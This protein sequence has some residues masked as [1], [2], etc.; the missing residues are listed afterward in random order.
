MLQAA[1]MPPLH[2]VRASTRP[3]GAGGGCATA[4]RRCCHAYARDAIPCDVV[5][6]VVGVGAVLVHGHPGQPEAQWA[7]A[8]QGVSLRRDDAS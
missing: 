6:C 8:G 7:Q 5:D 2:E 1:A 3:Q 4:V